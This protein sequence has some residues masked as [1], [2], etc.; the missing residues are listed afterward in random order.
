MPDGQEKAKAPPTAA[1][2]RG[3]LR[4]SPAAA[5]ALLP[6]P[7]DDDGRSGI[8]APLAQES[9]ACVQGVGGTAVLRCC[10]DENSEEPNAFYA[11]QA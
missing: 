3:R 4:P 7:A 8:V 5:S 9:T 10:N 1:Q 6:S 11:Q 2:G